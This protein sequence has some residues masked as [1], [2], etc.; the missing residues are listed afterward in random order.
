MIEGQKVIKVFSRQDK[1][2]EEFDELNEELRKNATTANVFANILMPIMVNLSYVNYALIAMV[3]GIFAIN[4]VLTIGVVIAFLQFTLT[5]SQLINQIFLML[6]SVLTTIYISAH[7][8]II[9][10]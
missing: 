2:I 5:L 3:G 6:K 4:E 8:F 10:V 9:L 1:V 7:F